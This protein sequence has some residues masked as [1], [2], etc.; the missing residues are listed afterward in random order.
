MKRMILIAALLA[1]GACASAPTMQTRYALDSGG[2]LVEQQYMTQ[3]ASG[4]EA[5]SINWC[6]AG[7]IVAGVV[8]GVWGLDRVFND[9]DEP[10]QTMSPLTPSNG[11]STTTTTSEFDNTFITPGFV[12]VN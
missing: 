8:L 11:F 2:N 5:G 3:K 6:V 7:A 1:L 10:T 9:D 12:T 4:C